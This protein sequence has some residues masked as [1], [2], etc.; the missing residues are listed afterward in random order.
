MPKRFLALALASIIS[1]GFSKSAVCGDAGKESEIAWG[2]EVDGLQMSVSIGRRQPHENITFIYIT[3]KNVSNET[4]DNQSYVINGTLMGFNFIIKDAEGKTIETNPEKMS[5][6][7]IYESLKKGKTNQLLLAFSRVC[8]LEK[9]GTYTIQA[10][11]SLPLWPMPGSIKNSGELKS[12]VFS[13]R[14]PD[15]IS[16]SKEK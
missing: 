16:P 8:D 12:N 7:C 6:S 13:F 10:T 1:L 9:A 5:R 3:L 15:D 11:R 2:E 14:Y 4:R